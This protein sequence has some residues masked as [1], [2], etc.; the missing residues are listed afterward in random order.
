MPGTPTYIKNMITGRQVDGHLWSRPPTA[1]A[2]TREHVLLPAG[3]RPLH[4][5]RLKTRLTRSTEELLDLV[6][7]V[8][9]LLNDTSSRRR[10]PDRGVS[11]LKPSRAT[12]SGRKDLG[13][14]GCVTRTSGARRDVAKPLMPVGTSCPSPAV[15]PVVRKVEQGIVKRGDEV[16]IVDCVTRKNHGDRGSRCPQASHQGSR[17]NIAPCW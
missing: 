5:V 14:H 3:R 15:A 12:R 8:A 9:Q 4:R 1:D 2:Q 16:E 6:E 17:H 10:H 11:A 13:A 7:R